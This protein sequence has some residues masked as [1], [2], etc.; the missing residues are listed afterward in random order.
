M[1]DELK[2]D[3]RVAE[4][5]ISWGKMSRSELEEYL[6][7]LEDVSDKMEVVKVSLDKVDDAKASDKKT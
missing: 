7:R 2:F 1:D 4:R 6:R 3:K 5:L